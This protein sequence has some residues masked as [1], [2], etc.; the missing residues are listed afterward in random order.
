MKTILSVGDCQVLPESGQVINDNIEHRLE[1]KAMAVLL[2]MTEHAGEIITREEL[3]KQVWRGSV[4]TYEALTVTINKIRAAL[5]DDSRHPRYIETLPKRGYRLIAEVNTSETTTPSPVD[6]GNKKNI[7]LVLAALI[8]FV[9]LLFFT[10]LYNFITVQ[11]NNQLTLPEHHLPSIAVIPFANNNDPEQDYFAA[12]ITEYLITD[13]S[14][15]ST[16]LVTSRNSVLGFNSK[17]AD[18]KQISEM[19]NVRYILTGSVLKNSSQIRIAVQLTDAR[20]GMQIWANRFDRKIDDLFNLQDEIVNHI[21]TELVKHVGG[22]EQSILSR[23][24]T[25]NHQAHDYFIRGNAL[26]TSISKEG[27]SLAREMFLKAIEIDPRFASAYGAIALTYVDDYRRKWGKN[28]AAAVDRAFEYANKAI[29]IDKDAAVAY[30]VL[31]YA[32]LYGRKEPEKAI[33][34]AKQAITLYPNYADAYAITGSAYSFID[35]SEDAIRVNQHAMRLNPTSSYIYFANLGRDYYFL[36]QPDKA[37]NSLQEGIFRNENYLN[38]HIY[39]AATYASLGRLSD[40][41]WEADK[42]LTID[43]AFSLNYWASTQPYRTKSRLERMLN[44]LYKAGLPE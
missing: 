19:L 31:A 14:R 32:Y 16:L 25:N 17:S 34:A 41:S 20:N 23:N 3:E 44:D 40:A 43:P 6:S 29:A 8:A 37:I 21:I 42:I 28:P 13:L 7:K 5:D 1:P 30:V 9:T 35:R 12:G 2:Y 27:N 22:S 39:L 24:Y 15:L 33:K 36:N 38:A 11:T 4:V 18:I 10:L 26:Y